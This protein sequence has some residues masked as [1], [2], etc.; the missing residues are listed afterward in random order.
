MVSKQTAET[1]LNTVIEP[2]IQALGL[3]SDAVGQLLLGTALQESGLV[4]R[5]QIG[6]GPA[7]GL[8]Q[9][10]PASYDDTYA[11]YLRYPGRAD[12]LAAVLKLAQRTEW[13]EADWLVA[14]DKFATAIARIKYLRSPM[15]IPDV[16]DIPGMARIY[17]L[18]YNGPGAATEHQFIDNWHATM[19]TS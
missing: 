16:N 9:C 19:G 10:E 4:H 6:G 17:K 3:W 1:F 8:F 7:L 14:H 12:M 18:V 5:R 13:P 11:N 2:A 15:P